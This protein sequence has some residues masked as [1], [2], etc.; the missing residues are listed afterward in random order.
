M[1]AYFV[2]PRLERQLTN[3]KWEIAEDYMCCHPEMDTMIVSEIP[4]HRYTLKRDG[5]T[6]IRI[7]ENVEIK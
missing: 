1:C 3:Q 6:F 7:H 2:Q 5:E 4:G